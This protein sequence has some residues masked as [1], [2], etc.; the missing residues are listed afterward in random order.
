M[1]RDMR[2]SDRAETEVR[3]QYRTVGSFLSDFAINFSEGGVFLHSEDPLPVGSTVRL[4][5]SL[6]NMPVLF[7][8]SGRVKWV[9]SPQ[10]A[11]ASG[12][13][14]GMGIEFIHI[15]EIIRKRFE[16][17]VRRLS[18]E[19]PEALRSSKPDRPRIQMKAAG[20]DPARKAR[21]KFGPA[22]L[23]SRH[24]DDDET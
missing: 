22:P 17:Y 14:P 16:A 2:K 6:P 3:V 15:D 9:E 7:D 5:F 19:M 12:K 13:L 24:R 1:A 4:I 10:Q 8:V 20:G 18:E 11:K 21:T 23:P